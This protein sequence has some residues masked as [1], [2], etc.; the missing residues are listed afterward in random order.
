MQFTVNR[1]R[2]SQYRRALGGRATFYDT[3]GTRD[4]RLS[5]NAEEVTLRV[6]APARQLTFY[7]HFPRMAEP[8]WHPIVKM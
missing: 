8:K 7:V 2:F 6:E 1:C 5:R 3:R 4:F